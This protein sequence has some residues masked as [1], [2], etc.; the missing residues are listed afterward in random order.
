MKRCISL[1]QIFYKDNNIDGLISEMKSRVSGQASPRWPRKEST[2]TTNAHIIR[3]DYHL[4]RPR[5]QFISTSISAGDSR[6][7]CRAGSQNLTVLLN[8]ND[9]GSRHSDSAAALYSRGIGESD[10]AKICEG[11]ELAVARRRTF[12]EVFY[13]PLCVV[14]AQRAVRLA[15]KSVRHGGARGQVLDDSTAGSLGS[16][17]YCHLDGVTGGDGDTRE[18]V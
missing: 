4:S 18:G 5:A 9:S 12:G 1:V 15:T 10:R 7:G 17:R 16:G 8:V 11:H 14:L 2:K 6:R 3:Y 13:N